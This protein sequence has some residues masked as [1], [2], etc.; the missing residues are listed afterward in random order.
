MR[1]FFMA[2]GT[3]RGGVRAKAMARMLGLELVLVKI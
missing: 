3:A 2:S 1:S